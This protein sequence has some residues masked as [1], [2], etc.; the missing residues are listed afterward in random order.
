MDREEGVLPVVASG[1]ILFTTVHV[2][3]DR[4]NDILA[5]E[6]LIELPPYIHRVLADN[7]FTPVIEKA[8]RTAEGY[9]N[10]QIVAPLR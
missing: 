7:T 8:S 10:K 2:S 5:A 9:S 1:L 6:I 4:A 3:M